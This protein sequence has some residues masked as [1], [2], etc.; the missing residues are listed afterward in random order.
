MNECSSYPAGD[1]IKMA[2]SLYIMEYK[3]APPNLLYAPLWCHSV[4]HMIFG[5]NFESE[6]QNENGLVEEG[7]DWVQ[8]E[9]KNCSK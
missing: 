2:H 9:I 6:I 3:T 5:W 1:W 8:W 7:A 4:Q